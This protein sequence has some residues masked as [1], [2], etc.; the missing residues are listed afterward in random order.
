LS[1]SRIALHESLLCDRFVVPNR[2]A[3]YHFVANRTAEA[4]SDGSE[5]LLP[6]PTRAT[7]ADILTDDIGLT[8]A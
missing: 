1:S 2:Q 4:P 8:K 3:L 5:Y 7:V 6:D